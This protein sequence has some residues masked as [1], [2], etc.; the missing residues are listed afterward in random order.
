MTGHGNPFLSHGTLYRSRCPQ[1]VTVPSA[2]HGT[3]MPEGSTHN[4]SR[5]L[6]ATESSIH[7]S[8]REREDRAATKLD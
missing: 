7:N 6:L 4:R 5:H 1:Q 2:G 8:N 3:L